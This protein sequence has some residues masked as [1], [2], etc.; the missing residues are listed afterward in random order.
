V[1]PVSISLESLRQVF[2]LI[3]K[4][5]VFGQKVPLEGVG[6][7]RYREQR[8]TGFFWRFV[9]F[10]PIAPFAGGD[11]I[12]PLVGTPSASGQHVISSQLASCGSVSTVQTTVIVPFKEGSVAQWWGE[13]IVNFTFGRN[14]RLH[15]EG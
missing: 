14:D 9:I 5:A 15:Y 2:H 1:R 7:K 6:S 3:G 11:N 13:G 4:N 10:L 8:H 12:F